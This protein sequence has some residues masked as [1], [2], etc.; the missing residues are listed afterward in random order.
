MKKRRFE[1]VSFDTLVDN[2]LNLED[3]RHRVEECEDVFEEKG[4]IVSLFFNSKK[5]GVSVYDLETSVVFCN[6]VWDDENNF[7]MIDKSKK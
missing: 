5:L 7:K 6:E 2:E 4:K 1:K 3:R